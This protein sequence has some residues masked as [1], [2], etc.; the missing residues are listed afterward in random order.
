M[1]M[2]TEVL[3]LGYSDHLAQFLYIKSKNLPKGPIT[4]CKRHFTVNNVE[5]Y[6]YLLHE[7]IWDEVLASNEPNTSFNLFM[8]TF[9]Y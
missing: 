1:T 4:T 6:K 5:E 2:F 7:E 3:D 8:N 9:T